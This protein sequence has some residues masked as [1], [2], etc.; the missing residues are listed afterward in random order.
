MQVYG[1]KW[2]ETELHTCT[3]TLQYTQ[4]H[5]G[6]HRTKLRPTGGCPVTQVQTRIHHRHMLVTIHSHSM[7]V[8]QSENTHTKQGRGPTT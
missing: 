1:F 4:I 7:A 5:T 3:D 8:G 6:T 2:T